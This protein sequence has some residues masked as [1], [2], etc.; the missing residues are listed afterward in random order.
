M[1]LTSLMR[2]NSNLP[3][4]NLYGLEGIRSYL[5]LFILQPHPLFFSGNSLLIPHGQ[6]WVEVN[7]TNRFDN[8]L[9]SFSLNSACDATLNAVNN[10]NTNTTTTIATSSSLLTDPW[11]AVERKKKKEI[12]VDRPQCIELLFKGFPIVD[13]HDHNR[14]GALAIEHSWK[15]QKSLFHRLGNDIVDS[16]FCF[17]HIFRS[18]HPEET[19]NCPTLIDFADKLAY[20]MIYDNA[21]S[22]EEDEATTSNSV[23]GKRSIESSVEY[24]RLTPTSTL[25]RAKGDYPQLRCMI[26]KKQTRLFCRTCYEKDNVLIGICS[27]E[28]S[29]ESTCLQQHKPV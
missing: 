28:R 2:Q 16:F 29:P 13:I 21:T 22:G 5:I 26:C 8:I 19:E 3:M 12:S 11:H 10:S 6:Q 14:Q 18:K 25:A 23:L 4:A 15:T 24:H 7:S 1:T 9:S 20:Q 27:E 17:R